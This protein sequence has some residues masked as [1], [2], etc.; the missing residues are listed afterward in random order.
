MRLACLCWLAVVVVGPATAYLNPKVALRI[1]AEL[2]AVEENGGDRL[3]YA[4]AI[5][6]YLDRGRPRD[7]RAWRERPQLS[8][9]DLFSG[10]LAIRESLQVSSIRAA[11]GDPSTGSGQAN[12]VDVST[13][14]GPEVKSHPFADMLHECSEARAGKNGDCARTLRDRK[15]EM[16]PLAAHVPPD[17]FYA[18]FS[19]L[20]RALDLGDY[21]NKTGGAFYNRFSDAPVDTALK[22]RILTQLAILEN[23]DARIFY[24]TVIAEMALVSS[25]FFFA[26]GT[27][28]SLLFKLKQK[29]IFES[30]IRMYRSKFLKETPS[31][32]EETVKIAGA[33][34]QF[35]STPD[36]RLRSYFYL[37]GDTAII[38]NSPAALARLLRV[39]QK[40]EPAL[41]S[42]DE[43][44][45][46]RSVYVSDKETEDGFIYFSDAFI[47]RLVSAQVR[48][49]EARRMEIAFN[50]A[51]VEKL[52]LLHEHAYGKTPKN[53]EE[54]ISGVA[55]DEKSANEMR[56]SFG[57][58]RVNGFRAEHPQWGTL[59]F[60]KPNLELPVAKVNQAEADGYKAFVESYSN[61][62]REYFDPIG[63]RFKKKASGVRIEI[64]ILP[65]IENSLYNQIKSLLGG[66]ASTHNI[67]S[68]PGETL[69]LAVR[70]NLDGI[71]SFGL[72]LH[73]Q[74]KS[75]A[76]LT[77][78]F[79]LHG[80]DNFPAIDFEPTLIMR[81][82]TRG[83][84]RPDVFFGLLA[85]SLF[86]PLRL[87]IETQSAN[88]AKRLI[89]LTQGMLDKKSRRHRD[90]TS[91][92]YAYNGKAITVFVL[93]FFHTL[94]F[95]FHAWADG[96]TIQ[97]TS[98]RE[99]AEKFIDAKKATQSEQG[100]LV[101]LYRPAQI[102]REKSAIVQSN[103]ESV[104]R[105][106][107][108]HLGT[109]KLASL[110]FPAEDATDAILKRYGFK[111]ICPAG[112]TY[113]IKNGY[114]THSMFGTYGTSRADMKA[115]EKLFADFFATEEFRLNFEFTPHG[116]MTVLETK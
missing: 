83:R 89:A 22:Q 71:R 92:K 63:I 38:S 116:I 55:L 77:G 48:I 98:T 43:F 70:A 9:F 111:P 96:K 3:G 88:D 50:L 72:K 39:A 82:L 6:A 81:E 106:C 16:F 32:K 47:R 23:K 26:M 46:M 54:L 19:S 7:E 87:A 109:V 85:W 20:T 76:S 104:Q 84:A 66:A 53:L 90:F 15:S 91:Y 62:W 79:Q 4:A 86:H 8:P 100:N 12:A 105:G 31:A 25:D 56:A 58:F 69:S 94:K 74:E 35:I 2:A 17:W 30:T 10:A 42:L 95:R 1:R 33:S 114:P 49:G 64:C 67:L 65:L 36:N 93:D 102:V 5:G 28:V 29:A 107:L 61:F 75:M 73:D 52:I 21:L 14:K 27:D 57:A 59:G 108:A 80:L 99:Y 115:I 41:A 11:K 78:N 97:I 18:H 13:L 37:A 113:S 24:D 44:K 112:G 103:A 60:L 101:A 51:Q 40:K 45:Y 34:V 110:I 68:M